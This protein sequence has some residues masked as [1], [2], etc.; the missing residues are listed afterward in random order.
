MP[1][2]TPRLRIRKRPRMN[3]IIFSKDRACQLDALLRS[4]QRYAPSLLPARVI[5]LC[6][7]ARYREGYARLGPMRSV[8]VLAGQDA[9]LRGDLLAALSTRN[10]LTAL[11]VDDAVFYRKLDYARAANILPGEVFAPRLGLNCCYCYTVDQP[12]SP[13]ELDFLRVGSLDG[14]IYHTRDLRELIDQC[15]F[16]TPN[17][18]EDALDALARERQLKLHWAAH[19]CLVNIPHNRVGEYDTRHAGGSAEELNDR[20]LAGERINL[21][22]MDFSSVIGPHQEIAY[23]FHSVAPAVV[24]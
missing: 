20:F 3:S 7:S 16:T 14:H 15:A 13:G 23:A 12:Q 10:S 5:Y 11:L 4:M 21:D 8:A 2:G 22:A 18:F 1:V 24:A 9:S 6:S 19:S 17:Q